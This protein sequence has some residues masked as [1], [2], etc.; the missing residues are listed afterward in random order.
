MNSSNSNF[1]P[2][3]TLEEE[4]RL[5]LLTRGIPVIVYLGVLCFLGTFGNVLTLAVYA[6]RFKPSI[7]RTFILWLGTVDLVACCVS[8]PY[9]IYDTIHPY[10]F[11]SDWTCKMLVL[12][13][14]AFSMYSPLLLDLIAVERYRRVCK[15]TER[16][17]TMKEARNASGM[18]GIVVILGCSPFLAMYGTGTVLTDR[19]AIPGHQC[20]VIVQYK[21]STFEKVYFGLLFAVFILLFLLC[22]VLY[23]LIGRKLMTSE[24][25]RR[26][27][28][29][30]RRVRRHKS[31]RKAELRREKSIKVNVEQQ[32]QPQP[33]NNG[34][35]IEDLAID[36]EPTMSVESN[37]SVTSQSGTCEL[38][39]QHNTDE[40][41]EHKDAIKAS[42]TLTSQG[43][44]PPNVKNDSDT[45]KATS[46][47]ND[48]SE[49]TSTCNDV[50][51]RVTLENSTA[52]EKTMS[53]KKL[54]RFVDHKVSKKK[55]SQLISK[56]K[57]VTLMFLVVSVLS[58]GGYLPYF[59]HVMLRNIS[60]D[61]E[62]Q[63]SVTFGSI[64]LI[65]R[66]SFFINNVVNP[67]VYGFMDRHFRDQL[68]RMI[69]KCKRN[70]VDVLI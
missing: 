10:T 37:V 42:A 33:A 48:K 35:N 49:M 8:I 45:P 59:V 16:Q 2:N 46:V 1:V 39:P 65:M 23:S 56:S 63:L 44:I 12:I 41:L 32:I 5:Q 61:M 26:A 58:F 19:N 66:Y 15:P 11:T 36:N 17:L 64:G 50:K 14:F 52:K 57:R 67:I 60:K 21:G 68:R 30:A 69:R 47:S 3:I 38:E 20:N 29:A 7:H 53:L 22:I 34:Q 55:I 27:T 43:Q 4:E 25:F 40:N 70:R 31:L 62:R 28:K 54:K 9:V 24:R 6:V 18:L 51:R 13:N